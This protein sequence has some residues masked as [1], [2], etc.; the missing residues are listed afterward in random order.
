MKYGFQRFK[1]LSIFVLFLIGLAFSASLVVALS[2]QDFALE[3]SGNQGEIRISAWYYSPQQDQ[4]MD[5]R[6]NSIE[7]PRHEQTTYTQRNSP[8]RNVVRC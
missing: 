6:D 8:G 7:E 5:R 2:Q 1:S 3:Q 4:V